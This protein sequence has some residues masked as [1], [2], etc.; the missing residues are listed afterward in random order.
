MPSLLQTW[1]LPIAV[2]AIANIAGT[3]YKLVSDNVPDPYLVSLT[4]E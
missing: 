1:A 4:V 2:L 3:W